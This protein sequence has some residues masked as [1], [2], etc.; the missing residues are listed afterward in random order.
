MAILHTF[1]VTGPG[2]VRWDAIVRGRSPL[3]PDTLPPKAG[4]DEGGGTG[5]RAQEP[6]R[7]TRDGRLQACG[8]RPRE[9]EF[10][11]IGI[12][13]VEVALAPRPRAADRRS[14]GSTA[15]PRV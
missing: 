10:V 2:R 13:Q 1:A 7:D 12:G 3:Q 14:S 15:R 8:G 6:H 11:T 9:T 5:E 4:L